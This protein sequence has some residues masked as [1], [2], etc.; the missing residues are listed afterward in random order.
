[1]VPPP[2]A[3]QILYTGVFS[4]HSRW[5]NLIVV[6]AKARKGFNP[7]TV[8]KKKVKNHRWAK[9]LMRIFRI[10]V[11][12]CPECGSDM[13]L[14]GAVQDPHSIQRYMRCIGLSEH[15]PPI[16]PPRYETVGLE[17]DE[18]QASPAD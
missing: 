7:E 16:A 9:L 1:M 12:T 11:G 15:P 10:D 4:S 17:W 8:D 6:D 5:R 18:A 2:R 13:Q 3:H 14:R